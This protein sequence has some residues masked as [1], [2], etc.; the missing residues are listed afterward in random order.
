MDS[1]ADIPMPPLP[2][3]EEMEAQLRRAEADVITGR[4]VPVDD[5]L[6]YMDEA[7]ARMD[8]RH[9]SPAARRA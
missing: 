5:V 7:I 6:R 4:V 3:L 9:R 1:E 2:S 8:A